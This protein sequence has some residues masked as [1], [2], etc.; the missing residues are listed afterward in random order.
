MNYPIIGCSYFYND[1][2]TRKF[3][4]EYCT[5]YIV[6]CAYS[7]VC[8][9]STTGS[10]GSDGLLLSGSWDHTARVWDL[11]RRST[12]LKLTGRAASRLP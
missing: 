8:F 12:L 5:M 7:A 11:K 6:H 3:T 2:F 10:R 9:L 1:N 4:Y